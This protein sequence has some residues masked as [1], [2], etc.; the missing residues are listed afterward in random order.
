MP[1]CHNV[2]VV[3]SVYTAF[4]T[5]VTLWNKTLYSI[6]NNGYFVE[7]N[8]IQHSEQWLLCGTKHYTAFRT[9]VTL[10]NKTLY[11]IQ[12][13]GYFVEQNTMPTTMYS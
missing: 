12:N 3:Y 10:W 2:H 4:R 8:T 5:M 7:Q 11:S 9:M 6:Q 1:L 13:N